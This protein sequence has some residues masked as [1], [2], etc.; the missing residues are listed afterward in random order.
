MN[1]IA[2][3]VPSI[4]FPLSFRFPALPA[5]AFGLR[6]G[7][8]WLHDRA[9]RPADTSLYLRPGSGNAGSVRWVFGGTDTLSKASLQADTRNWFALPAAREL[10]D[11]QG[12]GWPAR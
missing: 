7:R 10:A 5:S 8:R 2:L 3:G 9:S 6:G 4:F 11:R 1:P 12:R